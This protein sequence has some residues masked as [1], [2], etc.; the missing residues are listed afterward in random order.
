MA[1]TIAFERIG[2]VPT[3]DDVIASRKITPNLVTDLQLL[4]GESPSFYLPKKSRILPVY[5]LGGDP[6]N[7]IPVTI[8]A[9]V[10]VAPT[11]E[12]ADTTWPSQSMVNGDD[13][14]T[15]IQLA[16]KVTGQLTS[17]RLLYWEF[18]ISAFVSGNISVKV[19]F[20]AS[21]D[22]TVWFQVAASYAKNIT[23][24]PTPYAVSSL[25][26]GVDQVSGITAPLIVM[27][28]KPW[29]PFLRVRA[30]CLATGIGTIYSRIRVAQT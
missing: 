10:P 5:M 25:T 4:G 20:E 29:P 27:A 17:L 22:N 2:D 3:F 7:P 1:E 18:G 19:Y 13:Y 28:T 23:S 24:L 26:D 30:H 16:G 9:V 14:T 21:W 11:I 12:S 6:Q 8:P 15:A